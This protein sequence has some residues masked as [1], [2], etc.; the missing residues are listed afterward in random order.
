MPDYFEINR[1]NKKIND[2]SILGI[3]DLNPNVKETFEK[4]S[5]LLL[6]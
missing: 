4:N 6:K 1:H 5:K 3:K 2:A